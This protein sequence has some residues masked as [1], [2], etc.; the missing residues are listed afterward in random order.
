[1]KYKDYYEILGVSKTST[2]KE[3]KAAYRKLAKKYHPDLNPDNA[4]A[5]EKFKEVSEAYEV[6]SDPDKKQKYDTFGSNYDFTNGTNFDPS[7]YGY[8]YT[9]GKGGDFS[10]FFDMFFG[11]DAGKNRGFNFSDI[12]SDMGGRSKRKSST[13]QKYDTELSI[14]L[15]EAYLGVTR[16]V[17]LSLNGQN[18][19]MEVKIPAGITPG[20]KVKVKG[21]KY[22]IQGDVLFKIDVYTSTTEVLDGLDIIKKEDIYPWQAALG[23]KIVIQTLSGKLKIGIP[24]NFKG[25]NKMRIPKK[26]FKDLKGNEGDLYIEFNIVNPTNLNEEQ[27]N[28]YEKLRDTFK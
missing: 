15:E 18:I 13:R 14:S 6:L 26:G 16:N 21:E 25:G 22:G 17:S 2:D 4:E 27:I 23:D 8:S 1:M 20:K 9:S 7:Q 3:I 24:S 19:N 10:D 5:Q 12:F 28:L 11:G